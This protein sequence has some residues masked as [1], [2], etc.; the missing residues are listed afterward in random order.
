MLYLFDIDGTLIR[1]FMREGER[2][3]PFDEVE[4]LPGRLER[5]D[6]LYLN[7][8]A[9]GLVTNQGG[10]AFGYQTEAQ[11]FDKIGNV[12]RAVSF[13]AGYPTSVHVCIEHPKAKIETLRET[14]G[15]R[16]PDPGMIYEAM[17]VH[18]RFSSDV[19]FVGDMATDE[20]A[21]V[22]AGVAYQDAAVFF[23]PDPD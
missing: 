5:L 3:H 2:D 20:E 23:G 13:F 9:F 22:K 19:L 10:V 14:R 4:V 21:A 11:I 15:R 7:G 16:K 12:L 6:D 8:N 18:D 17:R 1:S